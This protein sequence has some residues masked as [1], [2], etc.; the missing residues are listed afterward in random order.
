M[1][2]SD[3]NYSHCGAGGGIRPD[4]RHSGKNRNPVF[5][6]II[7]IAALLLS[8]P[9]DAAKMCMPC[10]L[11][12]YSDS[13]TGGKC[14]PCP[15]GHYCVQGIRFVCPAGTYNDKA[16]QFESGACKECYIIISSTGMA[17]CPTLPPNGDKSGRVQG[18]C[19]GGTGGVSSNTN[20]KTYTGS[21]GGVPGSGR[22]CH[23]RA[24]SQGDAWSS[25]AYIAKHNSDGACTQHCAYYCASNIPKWGAKV[26]W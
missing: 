2:K 20:G 1:N 7:L 16:E 12:T 9:A 25:W 24:K 17:H 4:P 13:S 10:P 11:G 14:K 26:H 6:I 21:D 3:S 19:T 8:V 22:Y 5:N 23:C 18:Y 15:T